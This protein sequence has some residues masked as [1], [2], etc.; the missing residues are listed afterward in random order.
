MYF[1]LQ[2]HFQKEHRLPIEVYEQ[3]I[4]K[5]SLFTIVE[6]L[7]VR[8]IKTLENIARSSNFCD[9][10]VIIGY[11]LN[12]DGSKNDLLDLPYWF[13]CNPIFFEILIIIYKSDMKPFCINEN[14]FARF[15]RLDLILISIMHYKDLIN[16]QVLLNTAAENRHFRIVAYF[17]DRGLSSTREER[18]NNQRAAIYVHNALDQRKFIETLVL[19][20]IMLLIYLVGG[21][22]D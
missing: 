21:K 14:S 22:K 13:L 8:D 6:V 10:F 19:C 17:N 7:G 15:N 18:E 3:I 12:E 16:C 5:L 9:N 11:S 20:A 2:R 4:H 1:T